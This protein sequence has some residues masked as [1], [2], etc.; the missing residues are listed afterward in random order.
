MIDLDTETIQKNHYWTHSSGCPRLFLAPMEGIGND[1]FRKSISLIGGFDE[2][3]TEF[4]R[5]PKNAH[6]KGIAKSYDPNTCFPYPQAAQIMGS[7]P[8][9]VAE[10]AYLLELKGAPRIDLNCGCPS[11]IVVGRGAGSSLLQDPELIYEIVSKMAANVSIPVSVKLRSGFEDTSLLKENLQACE[12]ANAAFIALHP[13]TKLEGYRPPAHWELI[14]LAKD[15]LCIPVIG[16]G[17]IC[18]VEDCLALLKLSNCDG[19]M[20]GRGV[21]YNP[22]I[23]HEIKAHFSN[24]IFKRN[25]DYL[26]AYLYSYFSLGRDKSPK[27]QLNRLKA[28]ISYLFEKDSKLSPL[29]KIFLCSKINNPQIFYENIINTCRQ[30]YAD[31]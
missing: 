17:D 2:A 3:C 21:L 30:A 10:L 28:L 5:V 7:D 15:I 4:I 23:F 6:V 29:K 18:T 20:I 26:E 8:D 11:K 25:F 13:R 22:W 14:A 1:L 16:N 9:L 31:S 19:I 27:I 12:S 24:Q